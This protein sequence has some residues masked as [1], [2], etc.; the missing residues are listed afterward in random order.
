MPYKTDQQ[1]KA[2]LTQTERE[3]IVDL[4]HLCLYADSHIST[5]ECDTVSKVVDSIGWDQALSF[6]SYESRSISSARVAK[7]DEVSLKDF[8]GYA[9]ERLPSRTS[10]DMAIKLC[11]DLFKSDGLAEKESLMLVQI[12]SVLK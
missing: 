11:S 9:A 5:N 4:L 2:G 7:S 1:P 10:K 8:I 6:S 3:A 12:R